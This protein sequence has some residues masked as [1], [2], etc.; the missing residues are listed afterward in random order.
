MQP[1]DDAF[2]LGTLEQDHPFC[3]VD[4]AGGYHLWPKNSAN[5]SADTAFGI[6]LQ[7]NSGARG[8]YAGLLT[9]RAYH[10]QW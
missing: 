4:Q 9:I 8:E 6:Q 2:E 3:T 7:P 5:T 10:D 1:P